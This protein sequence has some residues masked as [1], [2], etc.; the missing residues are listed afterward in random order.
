MAKVAVTVSIL[1]A[2]VL[3]ACASNE[4]PT[5]SS[6][7]SREIVTRDMGYTPG[8]GVVQSATA[9]PGTAVAGGSAAAAPSDDVRLAIKMDNGRVQY[10]DTASRDFAPGTR[11]RLTED[12]VIM[13]E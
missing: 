2:A 8:T 6:E 5:A 13:R 4:R 11:V 1:A 3:A 12:R 7:P 9:V 10:V